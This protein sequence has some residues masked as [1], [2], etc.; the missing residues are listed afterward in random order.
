MLEIQAMLDAAQLDV[1]IAPDQLQRHFLAAV[2][3][4]EINL[5]ESSPP[6]A[7][8]DRIAR[9]RPIAGG[10]L[11]TASKPGASRADGG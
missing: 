7:P 8:L 1:E 11:Q 2:A 3:D 5:A 9:Q 4:G 6:H 10:K